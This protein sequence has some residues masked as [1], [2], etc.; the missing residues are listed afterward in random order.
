MRKKLAEEIFWFSRSVLRKK[1]QENGTG[2][3]GGG[4]AMISPQSDEDLQQGQDS[5]RP[6]G[7]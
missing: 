5:I 6:K 3:G 4:G 1:N 2:G 7:G